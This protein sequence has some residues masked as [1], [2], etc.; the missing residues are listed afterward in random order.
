MKNWKKEDEIIDIE[1][2]KRGVMENDEE[3]EEDMQI[4]K[5]KQR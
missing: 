4:L 2:N 1:Y 5:T 3:E